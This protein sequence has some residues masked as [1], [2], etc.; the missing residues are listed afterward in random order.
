MLFT[1]SIP[2]V[3]LAGRLLS[4]LH[5]SLEKNYSEWRSFIYCKGI[6]NPVCKGCVTYW[7]FYAMTFW[8][9]LLMT[10]WSSEKLSNFKVHKLSWAVN[11]LCTYLIINTKDHLI[12]TKLVKNLRNQITIKT[13]GSYTKSTH[14]VSC[15]S[16]YM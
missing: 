9:S 1:K 6:W 8:D 3:L 15:Y 12:F 7:F 14:F 16:P 4:L 10:F 13:L 11:E 5:S 2:N